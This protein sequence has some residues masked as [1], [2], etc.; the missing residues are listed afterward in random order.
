[1][2]DNILEI[3]GLRKAFRV[4]RSSGGGVVR[5]VSGIDLTIAKGEIVGLVG[6]SG[7]GKTT[8]GRCIL[9]LLAPDGGRIVLDGTD[10]TR[11]TQ[12]KLRPLRPKMHMVFQDAHSALNPHMTVGGIVAAPLRAQRTMPGRE[13]PAA[14]DNVLAK[15]GLDP[16]LRDRRP[17]ELSGGQRQRV[18]LARSLAVRPRLLVADEPTS[19]LDVSVQAA[20]LNQIADT[21]REFGFSCLFI[22]HDLA[23]V[24]YLCDRIAVMYQGEIVESGTREQIFRAPEHPYTRSLLAASTFSP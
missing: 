19:A 5:A 2:S 6:E 1:M 21:Q 18:G 17:H 3:T 4:P 23:V 22:S 10:I 9:R 15:V 12:R 13:V 8:V 20:I 7:S 24:E 16:A 14:V 11:L